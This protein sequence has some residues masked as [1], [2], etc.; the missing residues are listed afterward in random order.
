MPFIKVSDITMYYEIHGEGEPLLLLPGWGTEIST[1]SGLI[2]DLARNYQV[3]AIDN[4]GTGRSSR[5]DIPWTIEQMA[6]DTV[7]ILDA[8]GFRN[9]HILAISMSTM[10]A[11]TIAAKYPERVNGMVF[12]VGFHRIPFLTKIIMTILPHLPGMKKKMEEGMNSMILGQKY[13]P[14]RESFRLQGVAVSAF[15]G[16]EY[17]GRIT[18][19]TLIINCTRDPFVTV[20]ISKELAAGITGARLILADGDHL[21]ARLHP[22]LLVTPVLEFLAE[23]DAKPE[24]TKEKS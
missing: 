17:L 22:E 14:T 18:A 1:V 10:I 19:P 24:R 11:L 12:H 2:A 13:P 5:P 16:R 23:V 9:A 8:T 4:R 6:D 21:I 15:D 20:K 7:G 3:I